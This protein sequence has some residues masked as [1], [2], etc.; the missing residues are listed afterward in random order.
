MQFYPIL[1]WGLMMTMWSNRLFLSAG[2][3]AVAFPSYLFGA[4]SLMGPNPATDKAVTPTCLNQ[5]GTVTLHDCTS[6]AFYNTNLVDM[7][8]AF[9]TGNFNGTAPGNT[10]SFKSAFDNWNSGNTDKWTLQDGGALDMKFNINTF[11]ALAPPERVGGMEIDIGV[12][13]NSGATGPSLD[14]LVWT[15]GLYINYKPPSGVNKTN[16][17]NTLDTFSFSGG[18]SGSGEFGKA[19]EPIPTPSGASNTTPSNIPASPS[20]KAYCD[21][22]YPFQYTDK[23]FYDKPMGYYSIPASFRGIALLSTVTFK[24]DADKKITD[25]ILTV[26]NG[27]SYGFDLSYVP[28]PSFYGLLAIGFIVLIVVRRRLAATP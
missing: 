26:Y 1:A 15:Q 2:L 12:K 17:Y 8:S 11:K 10:N 25:R 18:P 24:T 6:K 21:P 20:E 14:Q 4:A 5:S 3:M 28:E 23:S 9:L 27:V 19:C 16:P 7:N 13:Y 22:I